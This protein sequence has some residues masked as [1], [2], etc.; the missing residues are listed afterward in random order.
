MQGDKV[1]GLSTVPPGDD[2]CCRGASPA[3]VAVE[4]SMVAE[5]KLCSHESGQKDPPECS[6]DHDSPSP[7]VAVAADAD[8]ASVHCTVQTWLAAALPLVVT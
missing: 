7:A 8:A 5:H 1:T 4:E 2:G 6:G 3:A